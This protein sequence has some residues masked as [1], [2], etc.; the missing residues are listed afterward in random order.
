M[1]L[2][3]SKLALRVFLD[4]FEGRNTHRMKPIPENYQH[5]M[6]YLVVAGAADFIEFAKKVFDARETYRVM[7]DPTTIQHAEVMIAQSTV[8]VA[9]RTPQFAEQPAGLFVYVD[10]ADKRYAM[11]LAAGAKSLMPPADQ[12]YGR[13]CGVKDA[14]GNTWWIT[15]P[16]D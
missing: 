5:V 6:P 12:T 14:W 11:A 2:G 16:K 15:T 7:R 1:S 8:M 13:S 10:D 4:V 3:Q 9:D